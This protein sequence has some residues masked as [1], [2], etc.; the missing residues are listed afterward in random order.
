MK[1][2]R[3]Y[4]IK[5]LFLAVFFLP[6]GCNSTAPPEIEFVKRI[7]WIGH[8]Q[9]LKVDTHMHT[10]FS[11]G[12][13]SVRELVQQ[14]SL[15]GCDVIA[16]TDHGDKNLKAAS[17]EYEKAI[18]EARRDFPEMIIVAGLE[19]NVP[20]WGGD[21]HATVLF[22]RTE[23]EW[24]DLAEFKRFY[25]DFGRSE[26]KI[27]T[28]E[29]AMSWL[30]RI[31]EHSSTPPLVIL[32]HP[33][34]K[35][36]S[37]M[38]VAEMI[39]DWKK[40]DDLLIG[41]S[42]APGH[43][44]M[45]PLGAFN[46]RLKTRDRWD[47]AAAV[48]GDAWDTL[49][50]EGYEIYAAR[51]ASD[52]HHHRENGPNG[53]DY[54]PGEF[55]ETW[56]YAPSRSTNGVLQ[57][58]RAGSFFANHGHIVRRVSLMI[59]TAALGRPGYA[60]ET[61]ELPEG[62][63][64]DILLTFL[65]P[66]K[67]WQNSANRI[68]Q[69]EI[70]AVTKKGSHVIA[71]GP[72]TEDRFST[73]I[74]IPQGGVVIRARGRRIE[75]D[76]PDLMFYTNP[77][78]VVTSGLSAANP[79]AIE[80]LFFP[81]VAISILVV[82]ILIF[83]FFKRPPHGETHSSGSKK[84]K[85]MQKVVVL[86]Q[87]LDFSLKIPCTVFSILLAG[88]IVYGSLLPFKFHSV[89]FAE[90]VSQYRQTLFE[91]IG[92]TSRIDFLT[93]FLL[94][95]PLGYFLCEV[96]IAKRPSVVFGM[97][98][99]I[100]I[101]LGCLFLSVSVEFSQIWYSDRIP[102]R[103]D[104]L[105]NGFGTLAGMIG[106]ILAGSRIRILLANVFAEKPWQSKLNSVLV[107]YMLIVLLISLIPL[108]LSISPDDLFGKYKRGRI[109]PIPFQDIAEQGEM[110]KKFLFHLL[111]FA[112]MG[113]LN[114]L[115]L[116]RYGFRPL[117][118]LQASMLQGFLFVSVTELLQVIVIS[119]FALATDIVMGT[120]AVLVGSVFVHR[121][122]N[123][124]IALKSQKTLPQH[125]MWF[126]FA[127]LY[128]IVPFIFYW[129]PFLME[130]NPAVLKDG[131]REF[132]VLPFSRLQGGSNMQA[133]GH[134]LHCFFFL[135]PFGVLLAKFSSIQVPGL[136]SNR[137]RIYFSSLFIAFVAFTFEW[138]QLFL[139]DRVADLTSALISMSG[140]LLGLYF[141]YSMV[142]RSADRSSSRERKSRTHSNVI[143][144]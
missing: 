63:Q 141:A 129:Y 22:P 95:I 38:E 21:V 101:F 106:W 131:V 45:T 91:A 43:Q 33:S 88:F 126:S 27:E 61:I 47:P 135:I 99:G 44:A 42:G 56:L 16:I 68:D 30:K 4:R 64:A 69:V 54:W 71:R 62:A 76:G 74:T 113:I 15:H 53:Y 60:G 108:D 73:T 12:A 37:S 144:R 79:S 139:K 132:F 86:P 13:H 5:L 11:D 2:H 117:A 93:N 32:N 50:Q 87:S 1:F 115:R 119:R 57:A 9:W 109:Q 133:Y 125:G 66:K 100:T 18:E 17:P 138:G 82:V 55:S 80:N 128:L 10:E 51:A 78:R 103:F 105:A 48:I 7:S 3:H 41:I 130:D 84:R 137:S 81:I 94:Y 36:D 72:P 85:V 120:L 123:S 111:L 116:R 107:V 31:G 104:I 49:L 52:F 110:L 92:E 112:P 39:R 19:W 124:E 90:A 114:T 59:S 70:I 40:N 28:R 23:N 20:P 97:L 102:S 29:A 98:K 143:S 35:L 14:A 127:L 134:M 121:I 96:W 34:R 122:S 77:I 46:Y 83:R 6:V 8:G 89:P 118:S 58:F 75:P 26:H 142:F 136:F 140:G 65:V 67:D 25:D 24:Q